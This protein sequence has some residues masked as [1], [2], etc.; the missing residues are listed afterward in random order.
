[1]DKIIVKIVQSEHYELNGTYTVSREL[2]NKCCALAKVFPTFE[3]V[4]T[5]GGQ[6]GI[7]DIEWDYIINGAYI[8]EETPSKEVVAFVNKHY[9]PFY[10]IIDFWEGQLE[11]H[12]QGITC[13]ICGDDMDM[14]L[15]T[16]LDNA[17]RETLSIDTD[18][19]GNNHFTFLGVCENCIT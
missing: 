18:T 5:D 19:E 4:W 16:C 12:C 11:S 6:G 9:E 17:Y 2:W 8:L 13:K 1:M 7:D 14:N 3:Y 10:T 15:D